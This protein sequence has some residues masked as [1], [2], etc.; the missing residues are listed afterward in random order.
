MGDD[1]IERSCKAKVLLYVLALCFVIVSTVMV[2]GLFT[3]N[4]VMANNYKKEMSSI[5]RQ[6]GE[7]DAKVNLFVNQV[8]AIKNM[9]DVKEIQKGLGK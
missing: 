5:Q 1:K 4:R 8:Q 6:I 7:R 9:K 2:V 3:T